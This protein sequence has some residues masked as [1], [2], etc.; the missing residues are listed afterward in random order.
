M[1]LTLLG[2]DISR[3]AR[4]FFFTRLALGRDVSPSPSTAPP[5]LLSQISTLGQPVLSTN[6]ATA[7]PRR[8]AASARLPWQIHMQIHMQISIVTPSN[9]QRT[10]RLPTRKRVYNSRS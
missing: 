1:L 4:S 6:H 7:P 3:N 2:F 8:R 5:C 9:R 10:N